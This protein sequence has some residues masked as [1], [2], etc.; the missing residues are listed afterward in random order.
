M[1]E[2]NKIAVILNIFFFIIQILILIGLLKIKQ[3][4]Y[5][6]SVIIA[7]SFFIIYIFIEN[8]Y[9]LYLNNYIRTIAMI[10]II[11][12]SFL[13]KYLNLYITSFSFD[14]ILHIF[15]VYAFTLLFYSLVN[16]LISKHYF[17][18]S[19]E[20]IFTILLGIS[21]GTILEVIECLIDIMVQS[22]IPHQLSLID[23]DIDIIS[24]IIGSILAAI[25]LFLIDF[26]LI[27]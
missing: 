18:R 10:S 1:K 11:S 17:S 15:G 7:T 13:G 25:H 2:K 16:Q 21:L 4:H 6:G 12:H 26:K 9:N 8:K 19:Y 20:V 24:N 14:I 27:K 22:E 5:M 23:T 3:Y